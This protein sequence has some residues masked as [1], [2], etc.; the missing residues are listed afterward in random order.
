M[1]STDIYTRNRTG[2]TKKWNCA[3]LALKC[4]HKHLHTNVADAICSESN[5]AAALRKRYR[6]VPSL[7]QLCIGIILR[8]QISPQNIPIELM[9]LIKTRKNK[10]PRT[11]N[12][13]GDWSVSY[14]T[15]RIYNVVS[16]LN[17]TIPVLNRYN[18]TMGLYYEGDNLNIPSQI[19]SYIDDDIDKRL[20]RILHGYQSNAK[21]I[22]YPNKCPYV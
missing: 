6:K 13:L 2:E 16:L 8:H 1:N 20:E 18:F 21:L 19:V 7:L 14:F 9:E 5:F 12:A 3:Y 22:H 4:Y 11:Y 17:Y 10:S 15:P